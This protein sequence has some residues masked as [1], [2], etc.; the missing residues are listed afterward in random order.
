MLI[1]KCTIAELT[2]IEERKHVQR[3]QLDIKER[4]RKKREEELDRLADQQANMTS[5]D[6]TMM[7]TTKG[8]KGVGFEKSIMSGS[9]PTKG[10]PMK[11]SRAGT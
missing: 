11:F 9:S 1:R 7:N 4:A 8:G 10:S 3:E 2:K 6:R 5:M